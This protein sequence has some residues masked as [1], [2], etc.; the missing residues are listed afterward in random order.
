ME[1]RHPER[2]P[3]AFPVTPHPGTRVLRVLSRTSDED[4]QINHF[5]LPTQPRH[6]NCSASVCAMFP[7]V[8]SCPLRMTCMTSMPAMV[9]RAAQN[10]L[11]PSI[12]RVIRFTARWSCS[13]MLLRYLQW[14][15]AI[16][17]FWVRL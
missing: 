11:K 7:V 16:A 13:T 8:T 10:D 14:R 12:G 5:L 4:G 2:A 6:R 15:M 9:Q 1:T 3:E 17:V